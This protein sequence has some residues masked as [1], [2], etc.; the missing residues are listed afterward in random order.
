MYRVFHWLENYKDEKNKKNFD[1]E[2][3]LWPET[4]D[5]FGLVYKVLSRSLIDDFLLLGRLEKGGG[6]SWNAK[7]VGVRNAH[8]I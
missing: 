3:D 6:G 2:A 7:Q 5:F 8:D 1:F 4:G